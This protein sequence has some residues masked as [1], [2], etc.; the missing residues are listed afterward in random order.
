MSI[1][2]YTKKD[3]NGTSGKYY[4]LTELTA[5]NYATVKEALQKLAEEKTPEG[6]RAGALLRAFESFDKD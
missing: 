1:T 3:S 6:A 2:K 5:L 4:D